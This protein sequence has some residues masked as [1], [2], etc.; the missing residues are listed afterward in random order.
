MRPGSI[1]REG[2]PPIPRA[3]AAD[4]WWS[5]LRGLLARPPLAADGSEALLIRPCASVHTV[6]MAYPLDLVFLDREGRVLEWREQVAPWRAAACRG[7]AATVELHGGA[8]A[9][10]RPCAGE[11]WRWEP[12]AVAGKGGTA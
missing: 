3:W 1:R 12:A 4:R 10:L 2:A 5:R 7:A 9:R 11:R 8:L 6:G